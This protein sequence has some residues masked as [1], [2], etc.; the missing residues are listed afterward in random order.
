MGDEKETLRLR[1]HGHVQGI[2]FR[3]ACKRHAH[4]H[5]VRGWVSNAGN[6]TVDVLL[7]GS[8]DQVDRMLSWLGQGPEGAQVSE[9]EQEVLYT[10]MFYDRFEIR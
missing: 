6:G 9:I 8:P 10:D 4:L 7:Q 3:D 1:V 5:G 2:G